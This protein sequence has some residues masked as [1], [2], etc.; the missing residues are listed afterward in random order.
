M[1]VALDLK[2][3][4]LKWISSHSSF[5]LL[6]GNHVLSGISADELGCLFRFSRKHREGSSVQSPWTS[7]H[8]ETCAERD[9]R[10]AR[11]AQSN[12]C[13]ATCAEQLAQSS[14]GRFFSSSF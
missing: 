7:L 2:L 9:L 6:T 5:Q 3:Q 8:R 12:L 4:P 14:L 11:L 1:L 13:R 10:R